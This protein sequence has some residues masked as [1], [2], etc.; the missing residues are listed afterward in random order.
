MIIGNIMYW[1]MFFNFFAIASFTIG[2]ETALKMMKGWRW[3]K[4]GLEGQVASVQRL[5]SIYNVLA[6][7]Q[8]TIHFTV[9]QLMTAQVLN[10]GTTPTLYNSLNTVYSKI[11]RRKINIY[12][13]YLFNNNF[14]HVNL[15]QCLF[16]CLYFTIFWMFTLLMKVEA[17]N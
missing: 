10:I 6:L 5:E 12:S 11:L 13:I 8:Y 9:E 1:K 4:Q 17:L 15:N 14:L 16:E 3:Q 7:V 2:Q